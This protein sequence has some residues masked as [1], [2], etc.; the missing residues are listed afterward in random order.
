MGFSIKLY[1]KLI[2]LARRKQSTF[3]GDVDRSWLLERFGE[4]TVHSM[5]RMDWQE[6]IPMR[7]LLK[8]LK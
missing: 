2:L 7:H 1:L 3:A 5:Y 8:D 4:W 6:R